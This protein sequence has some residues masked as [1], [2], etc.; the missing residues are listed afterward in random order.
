[1]NPSHPEHAAVID[2]YPELFM[3]PKAL[4]RQQ[5]ARA[6]S[7]Q[8]EFRS[9][10]V[11][12]VGLARSDAVEWSQ[13]LI[14]EMYHFRIEG[15]ADWQHP[16]PEARRQKLLPPIDE[17]LPAAEPGRPITDYDDSVEG[18]FPGERVPIEE[19]VQVPEPDATVDA[20]ESSPCLDWLA[21]QGAFVISGER[22][23]RAANSKGQGRWRQPHYLGERITDLQRTYCPEDDGS[24]DV[25]RL[26]VEFNDGLFEALLI[27]YQ[28]NADLVDD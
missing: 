11:E 6:R 1:M 2:L 16:F 23:A 24:G 21:E 19:E 26:S 3:N 15:E 17:S 28:R 5:L 10:L 18:S 27:D 22:S 25:C 12:D 13:A 9:C 7:L 14:S 20:V 4:V 8:G